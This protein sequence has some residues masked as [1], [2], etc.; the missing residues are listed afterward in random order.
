MNKNSDHFIIIMAGGRGER[1]WPVSRE[2][3]P[4]QLITILGERSFLQSTVDRVLPL[5]PE[6]NIFIITNVAQAAEVKRQ[7]PELPPDNV[8]AEPCGRD[9]C[10]AVALGAALVG[11][12]N[13]NGIMAVL[14]ADHVIPENEKFQS[15]LS[16]TLNFAK[17]GDKIITIGIKPNEPATGYGYIHFGE[18]QSHGENGTDLFTG[19]KFVEKP[20]LPTAESYLASGEYRWNAGMFIWSYS[21][22]KCAL[23]KYQPEIG[24]LC[25]KWASSLN[26][27]GLLDQLEVDYPDIKKI[28]IDFAVMEKAQNVFV[29]DGS[30]TW[31][32]LGAWTALARHIDNDENGNASNTNFVHVDSQN[33]VIFDN[34]AIERRTPI[35]LVGIKNSIIVQTEDALLVASKEESQKIKDLVKLLSSSNEYKKLT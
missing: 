17:E 19:L 15:V 34:R 13:P 25:S 14:P 6:E 12:K 11:Q 16:D 1:F 5:V 18:K 24:A 20:D 3:S 10:A 21:T 28:S 9:T 29:A 33:N 2:T 32:D 30:F 7:L 27:G 35:T 22:I 4:K 31:D 23:D 8:I 26:I